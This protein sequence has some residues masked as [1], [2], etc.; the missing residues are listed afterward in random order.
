MRSGRWGP[1]DRRRFIKQGVAAGAG[2]TTLR[3]G[4]FNRAAG[5]PNGRVSVGIMGVNGRGRDHV[6]AFIT[7][8]A[9]IAYVCDVDRRALARA[10]ALAESKQPHSPQGA[11]D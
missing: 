2:L 4:S 9:E 10:V 3:M 7:A 11:A 5:S 8:G 1:M 6:N